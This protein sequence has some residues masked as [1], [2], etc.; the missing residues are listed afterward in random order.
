MKKTT[1][2]IALLCI[3]TL[4]NG[5][6]TR[7]KSGNED[8]N[9]EMVNNKTDK[10]DELVLDEETQNWIDGLNEAVQAGGDPEHPIE[11]V[12]SKGEAT[13]MFTEFKRRLEAKGYELKWK[14]DR[15][16]LIKEK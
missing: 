3:I 14:E 7:A 15:Y 2:I 4:S 12:T 10:M 16:Y 6:D 13:A 9:K 5:C 1:T 8:T 11:G